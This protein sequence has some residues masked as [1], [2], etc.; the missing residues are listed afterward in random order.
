MDTEVDSRNL[1][2][3][4]DLLTKNDMAAAQLFQAA[5]KWKLTGVT[6]K[7]KQKWAPHRHPAGKPPTGH[8]ADRPP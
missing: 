7:R 1:E 6:Q 8:L 3:R 2:R 5:D 4:S